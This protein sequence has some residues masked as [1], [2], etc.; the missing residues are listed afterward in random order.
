MLRR[1]R[2]AA[3]SLGQARPPHRERYSLDWLRR[4]LPHHYRT[5]AGA[6][7]SRLHRELAE[8]IAAAGEIRDQLRNYRAPRGAAKT[9]V[10]TVGH[11]LHGAVEG[12]EPF[13]LLLSESGE[14]AA[15]FLA[16]IKAEL[17]GNA[18]LARAY[19]A[20]CGVGPVWKGDHVVLRNGCCV[21][22]RGAGGRIRGLKHG[23]HRPTLVILDD[24]NEK[25]DAYSPTNRRRKLD[26]VTK[27]VM[28]VGGPGTNFFCFGTPIHREAIVCELG[29][30]G[31]WATRAY[32]AVVS[33][34]A[35]TDLWAEWELKLFHHGDPDR[36]ATAR[37]FYEANRAEMD[38][39]AAVLWPERA[40]LY[41]LMKL[42]AAVGP[43][44]FGCEQQDEPGTDGA[45]EWP[46][47][48]FD[49]PDLWFDRWPEVVQV[50]GH[51]A[52]VQSL[53][54]SKGANARTS[55]Y[56]AHARV[57]FGTDGLV[58]V[59]ADL[60]RED[61]LAM[62]SRAL[63]WAKEVVPYVLVAEG[64]NT[65][66]LLTPEFERQVVERTRAGKPQLFRYEE[67]T[68]IDPKAQR[69]RPVG[70]YLARH[71]VRVRN[72]PGGRMLV[73]QWRDWP[74][75]EFDD[76]PDAVATGLARLEKFVF[77]GK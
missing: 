53:D 77:E 26:W 51:P 54:P 74:N 75:G 20:A 61:P 49:R 72:T 1:L 18:E 34:P 60:R 3:R 62:C 66:G 8:D 24:P 16:A 6:E 35:R 32:K 48:W 69:I 45:T 70:A 46:P 10:G 22:T 58:Y 5:P 55:D 57:G 14:I 25:G 36:Q 9:T 41:D 15:T 65:L 73:D 19:P 11:A 4:F 50:G 59:E 44:A 76:G 7:P 17:E 31:A 27:D 30:N 37:R 56:Q 23:P 64:N 13:A 38:R 40:P 52:L 12:R 68:N 71:Q 63:D 43:T 47:E 42:R 2:R 28:S 67:T 39:G 21:M 33:W 29:R